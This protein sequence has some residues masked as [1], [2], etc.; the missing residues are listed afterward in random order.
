MGGKKPTTSEREIRSLGLNLFA[1]MEGEGK[2]A[3]VYSNSDSNT[4]GNWEPPQMCFGAL[5]AHI[6]FWAEGEKEKSFLSSLGVMKSS[7]ALLHHKERKFM[8]AK[9]CNG[10]IRTK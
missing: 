1:K 8:V 2:L 10:D 3:F 6:K 5:K 9:G 4:K 7:A